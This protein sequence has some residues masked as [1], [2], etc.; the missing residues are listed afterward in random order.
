MPA[1][2]CGA[3]EVSKRSEQHP[4]VGGGGLL[5]MVYPI[6]DSGKLQLGVRTVRNLIRTSAHANPIQD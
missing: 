5:T 3:I 6:G 2:D 1:T 4:W